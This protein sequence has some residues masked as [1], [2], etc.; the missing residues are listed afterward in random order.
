MRETSL[1]GVGPVTGIVHHGITV[2]D[3]NR[4][5]RLYRDLLGLELMIDRTTSDEYLGDIH[6]MPFSE[7]R[8]AF[9]TAPGTSDTIEIVQYSG[10]SSVTAALSP[11]DPGAGHICLEVGDIAAVDRAIRNAGFTPLSAV[12]IEISSGPNRG[13]KVVKFHDDDG[14]WVELWQPRPV[15]SREE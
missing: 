11:W 12:P 4:S 5:L 8:M 7:V 9:L 2:A 13:A 3:V 15:T 14:Y 10:V 6:G 1:A